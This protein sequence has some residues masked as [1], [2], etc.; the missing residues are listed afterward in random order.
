MPEPESA[1][2]EEQL[3]K[4]LLENIECELG[5]AILAANSLGKLTLIKRLEIA[6]REMQ[7]IPTDLK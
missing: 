4:Q 5:I 2:W 1:K 6:Y 7:A 3:L